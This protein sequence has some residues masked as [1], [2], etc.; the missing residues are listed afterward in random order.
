[1]VLATVAA[2]GYLA[3]TVVSISPWSVLHAV[4]GTLLI[5]ASGSALNQAIERWLDARMS[6]TQDRPLPSRRLSTTE[7]VVFGTVT[8]CVGVVYL[9]TAIGP[10]TAWIGIATWVLYVW[11]YT[12]LKTRTWTNTIVGAVAGAMPVLIG[13][14]ATGAPTHLWIVSLFGTLFLWQFPHFMAIAWLYRKEYAKGGMKMLPVIDPSGYWSGIEAVV[15]AVALI[16]VIIA[17]A[18]VLE[19]PIRWIYLIV[20]SI[21]SLFYLRVLRFAR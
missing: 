19:G 3:S 18:W 17:P 7:V 11:I 16:P 13:W 15:T 21:P 14:Y 12:P 5:A 4:V 2:A 9:A 6:R 1:M 10:A 20:V 8:F